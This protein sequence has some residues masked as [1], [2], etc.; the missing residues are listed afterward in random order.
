MT[1]PTVPF[2][3]LNRPFRLDD[4]LPRRPPSRVSGGQPPLS[5]VY[6]RRRVKV[7]PRATLLVA[8]S[9]ARVRPHPGSLAAARG[10]RARSFV[11][12]PLLC[13]SPLAAAPR[14]PARALAAA[15]RF[16]AWPRFASMVSKPRA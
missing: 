6:S 5:V 11:A 8:A 10:L 7:V 9:W 12:A 2:V 3:G 13:A 4:P 15:S 1:L 16:R 14:V